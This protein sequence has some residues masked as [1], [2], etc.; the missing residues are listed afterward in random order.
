VTDLSTELERAV[1][2]LVEASRLTGAARRELRD[3]LEQHVRDAL[4][5]GASPDEVVARL[6]DPD[7]AGALLAVGARPRMRRPNHESGEAAI[8][9]FVG[10][11]R[12]GVRTLARTPGMALT[13]IL[14]LGLGM[15]TTAM[16]LTVVNEILL[17]PLPVADQE[18]LVDIWADV[19]G[20]NSFAGF[21]WQD[22][23]EYREVVKAG[24]SGPL[25]SLA[26]FAGTRL[27]IGDGAGG[28][29]V[30]GQLVS[31][32]YLDVMGLR[33]SF[34]T[35]ELAEDPAFGGPG[36]AVLSHA[37]WV[38]RFGGD[39][40]IVGRTVRVD[41]HSVTVVGV[42]PRGFR[43]HFIGFPVDLWLP[44]TTADLFLRGFSPADRGSMPF[45]MIGRRAPGAT[46][47]TVERALSAVAASL[48]A[49]HP[50]THEGHGVGVTPTTGVDRSLRGVVVA[51]VAVLTTLAV[52]VLVIA[53]LNVGSILLVRT[54]S[55]GREMAVR[56]A[57]GAGNGRL[58]RQILAETL[59]LAVLGTAAGLGLAFFLN[60]VLADWFRSF[61]AGLGLE[62]PLDGGV[63]ALTALAGAGAVLLAGGAPALHL[64]RKPPASALGVRSGGAGNRART[65]LVV[66][67]VAVSVTL[68]VATGL[69]LRALAAGA[70]ADPG[71]DADGVATFVVEPSPSDPM[72][73][74]ESVAEAAAALPG[75]AAA[76]LADAPPVGV[77]RT[78]VRLSLPGIPPPTDQ[79]A[80]AVDGRRVG[81]G[82]IS[83]LGIP[84]I[85]GR[86]LT[87]ADAR[88][89]PTVAVVSNAFARRFWPGEDALGRSFEVQGEVVR[90]VGVAA[91]VR[92]L[93]QDETPDPFVYLSLA[94]RTPSVAHV[95]FRAAGPETLAG[96]VGTL[97]ARLRPGAGPPTLTTPRNVLDRA[98]LPQRLGAVLVGAMGAIALM[99]TAVGLY[100]LIQ[101]TVSRDRH[102]LAVRLALGGSRG[103]LLT[104]VL[105]KGAVLVA[106]GAVL[107]LALAALTAPVLETF[108]R[109]V[110][111]TDPLTYGSVAVLF[112]AVALL[113]SW[114][115]ARRAAR[116][117]PAVALRRE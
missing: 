48:E 34:G 8:L 108:L 14:V 12:H 11:L 111:P 87:A 7:G 35:L 10:D 56:L 105:R 114:I 101:Y 99:L 104:T 29:S 112:G 102:E 6:G 39:E 36:Q 64:L 98:L 88:E 3:D 61:T 33:P 25:E 13:A 86:D 57:L 103:S 52:L 71:F 83:T 23:L 46:P 72:M 90:V 77:A 97:L 76:T 67:Q 75:V 100:G 115:P 94:G 81:S 78:P 9:A 89:G 66:S 27:S 107:G 28:A 44:I 21:G 95:T 2:R 85:A 32:E 84:L 4:E 73:A 17:R 16:G 30:T 80:W 116:I 92:Y 68:A 55:R 40:A 37:L 50:D 43:G 18:Q 38:E 96:E 110:S 113:A 47:E 109:G 74:G 82:Y 70:E 45:E 60:G 15:A 62:L 69:F 51:F 53:C 54:L 41:G 59:V 42:A 106:S 63:L 65:V 31:R 5:T 19:T 20:G 117:Q 49:A 58:V 93:V 91:D 24:G 26:A 22:Y 79:E 1:A